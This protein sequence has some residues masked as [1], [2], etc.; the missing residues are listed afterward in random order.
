MIGLYLGHRKRGM[1]T[2]GFI[3]KVF[4]TQILPEGINIPDAD[5]TKLY[6]V[7]GTDFTSRYL[8]FEAL[9]KQYKF[10]RQ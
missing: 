6:V 7:Y 3:S 10:V 8:S 2:F 9:I 5:Y 1:D 4:L